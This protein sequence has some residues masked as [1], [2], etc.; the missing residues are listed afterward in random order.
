MPEENLS[1]RILLS[2]NSKKKEEM[3][4]LTLIEGFEGTEEELKQIS[5]NKKL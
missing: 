3:V 2:V 4:N 1:R 5:K